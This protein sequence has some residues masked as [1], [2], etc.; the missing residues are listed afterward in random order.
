[1]KKPVVKSD[2]IV[3]APMLPYSLT[4]DHR[5]IDGVAAE[6]FLSILR[7]ILENPPSDLRELARAA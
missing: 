2:E 1:M 7:D 6:R 3:I 5:V 4:H